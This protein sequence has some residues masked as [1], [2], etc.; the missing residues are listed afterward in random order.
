M[1]AL[2]HN[3]PKSV[4]ASLHF[5]YWSRG[6]APEGCPGGKEARGVR[7]RLDLFGLFRVQMSHVLVTDHH[8]GP[9]W[10]SGHPAMPR[11]PPI[12]ENVALDVVDLFGASH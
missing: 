7:V 10:L 6:L 5:S 3:K 11:M 8:M 2:R 9:H 4:Q 12:A 1:P